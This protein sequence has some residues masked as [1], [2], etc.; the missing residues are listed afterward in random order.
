[1]QAFPLGHLSGRIKDEGAGRKSG[2]AD[3]SEEFL[4]FLG[5]RF[6]PKSAVGGDWGGGLRADG[7]L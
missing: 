1:M 2:A 4:V 7:L 3:C 6:S 5:G